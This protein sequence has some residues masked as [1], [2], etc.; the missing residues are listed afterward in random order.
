MGFNIVIA[1]NFHPIYELKCVFHYVA[2]ILTS[3][4]TFVFR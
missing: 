2:H 4:C 3:Y 1:L